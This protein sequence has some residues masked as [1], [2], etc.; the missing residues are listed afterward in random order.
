MDSGTHVFVGGI[1]EERKKKR[2]K[3]GTFIKVLLPSFP[4]AVIFISWRSWTKLRRVAGHVNL[5]THQT[6]KSFVSTG[7]SSLRINLDENVLICLK[8]DLQ[9]SRFVEWTIK[10]HHQHLMRDVRAGKRKIW[11]WA[12]ESKKKGKYLACFS[13]L[14]VD[15][16]RNSA[17]HSSEVS[18]KIQ[19][20]KMC[21][22]LR[23]TVSS[24]AESITTMTFFSC[25]NI[26]KETRPS[27]HR[28]TRKNRVPL[29]SPFC[30]C[31]L[32]SCHLSIWP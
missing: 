29:F 19:E 27:F 22:F 32:E 13:S 4:T 30:E 31:D 16:R 11:H 12:P 1:K 21:T 20:E 17:T 9:V 26:S 3:S 15:G 14:C 10:Q 6:S 2:R 23:A 24:V 25:D 18:E 28:R 5:R 8:V 7:D